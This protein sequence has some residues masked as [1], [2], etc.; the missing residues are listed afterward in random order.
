VSFPI[1]PH[2]RARRKKLQVQI[3]D[4]E[5]PMKFGVF[6]EHY[7]KAAVENEAIDDIGTDPATDAIRGF[8]NVNTPTRPK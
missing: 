5:L 4:I 2:G 1:K 3:C 7:L 6:G 8:N